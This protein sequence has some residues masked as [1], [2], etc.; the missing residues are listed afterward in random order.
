MWQVFFGHEEPVT[1]F[2]QARASD[3][4]FFEHLQRECQA[5]GAPLPSVE[6]LA[7][8][9]G[10]WPAQVIVLRQRLER[11]GALATRQAYVGRL[12]RLFVERVA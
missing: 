2:R 12:R 11:E 5:R 6:R 7:K 1:R 4:R 9:F 8:A 10:A 3:T